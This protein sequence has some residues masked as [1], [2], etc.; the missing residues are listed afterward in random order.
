MCCEAC[1]AFL[2]QYKRAIH[3][4]CEASQSLAS[5]SEGEFTDR[6]QRTETARKN[7]DRY[8]N[9]FL[10]HQHSHEPRISGAMLDAVAAQMSEDF[11]LGDQGQPGG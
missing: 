2:E 11:I 10:A 7:V 4:Y 1:L 6:W 3:A 9:D 5:T 8:R